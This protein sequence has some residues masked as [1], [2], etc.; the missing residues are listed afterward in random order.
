MTIATPTIDKRTFNKGPIGSARHPS[1]KVVE[2]NM[3]TVPTPPPHGGSI[4]QD[5]YA[6]VCSLRA[7]KAIKAEFDSN[8]HAS[9]V[10]GKMRHLAKK[11]GQF[12]ASSKLPDGRT[13]WFWLEK[14]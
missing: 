7:G 11:D 9:Y 13:M 14:V 5:L 10:R 4:A 12:V 8:A 6:Q 2:V 3:D 1:P